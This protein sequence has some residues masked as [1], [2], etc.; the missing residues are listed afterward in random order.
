MRSGAGASGGAG[1]AAPPSTRPAYLRPSLLGTVFAGGV[2]GTCMRFLI[3][4][5]W[6]TPAG[7][8]PWA[9]FVINLSGSFAL[10]FLTTLLALTGPDRGWRR[11][12]RLGVGTGVIGGY[13]TYSTFIV[14]ASRLGLGRSALAAVG[15]SVGSILL[16]IGCAAL[17]MLVAERAT[18]EHRGGSDAG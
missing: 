1:A 17:G 13:T 7:N 14:E 8:W 12:V 16:G 2:I 11:L 3:E 9:T 5:A 6:P 4:S 18:A 10:G 15:Y